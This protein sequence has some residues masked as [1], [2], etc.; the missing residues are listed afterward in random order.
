M[1]KKICVFGY[2]FPHPKTQNGLIKLMAN[3][4]RPELVILQEAKKLPPHADSIGVAPKHHQST[5]HPRELCKLLN[6][7]YVVADHDGPQAH[8]LISTADIDFGV[9]LGARILK[10]DTIMLFR[11]GLLNM[12]PG[13]LP[14]NRGLDNLKRAI[15]NDIEPAVTFHLID[16]KIDQ[17]KMIFIER[18]PIYEHD[19]IQSIFLRHQT[20]ELDGM[21]HA[22]KRLADG[23]IGLT[24][25]PNTNYPAPLFDNFDIEIKEKFEAWKKRYLS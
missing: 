17:G 21:I 24:V 8:G 20:V 22:I 18:V 16:K 9:I 1:I 23:T 3:G 5:V 11:N 15:L 6:L 10:K 19:T 4:Y 12:H 7:P 25:L 14:D 2:D 13:K